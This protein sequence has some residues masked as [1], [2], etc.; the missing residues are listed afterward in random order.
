M[1]TSTSTQ[2]KKMPAKPKYRP[3][4]KAPA[5]TASVKAWEQLR[6]MGVQG[7][8]HIFPKGGHGLALANPLTSSSPDQN[9]PECAQWPEM[10]ARFLNT[11]L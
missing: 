11:I 3:M 6:R 4:P 10:A 2:K 9:I 1:S 5:M 7:E 8:V